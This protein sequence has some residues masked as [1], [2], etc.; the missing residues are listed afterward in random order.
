MLL[1]ELF[2]MIPKGYLYFYNNF[3]TVPNVVK[4]IYV[5]NKDGKIKV[6][7]EPLS[8]DRSSRPTHSELS[9]GFG[10][11]AA[12]ELIF[13]RQPNGIWELKVI[14]NGSGHYLPSAH[15]TLPF[16]KKAILKEDN[17]QDH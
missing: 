13:H 9:N 15:E 2:K 4:L 11:K 17:S 16:A 6:A 10:V 8:G 12:G 5:V 1:D 14:N 3:Y 7:N